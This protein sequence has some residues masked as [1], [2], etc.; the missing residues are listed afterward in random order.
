MSVSPVWASGAIEIAATNTYSDSV[1][2]RL[3]GVVGVVIS[4]GALVGSRLRA[5]ARLS[6]DDTW[7]DVSA[8][9]FSAD[10]VAGEW[11]SL[12]TNQAVGISVFPYVRFWLDDGVGTPQIQGS[13]VTIT[14]VAKRL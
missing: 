2:L 6:P 10:V 14:W 8:D 12:F 4:A 1:D 13:A 11:L 3:Y 9:A 5:Q 7:R